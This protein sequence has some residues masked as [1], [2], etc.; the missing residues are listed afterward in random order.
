MTAFNAKDTIED[1]LWSVTNQTFSD[2]EVVIVDD[3]S[4]DNTE[5]VVAPFL[6]DSRIRL[7]K[8]EY[9]IGA[10]ASRNRAANALSA[11]YIAV[12]DADD[13][14]LPSRLEAQ[15]AAFDRDPRLE[16]LGAQVAEFGSWGGP[17]VG[18]AWPTTNA[19]IQA[20]L[21]SLK[22]PL[23]HPTLMIKRDLLLSVGGYATLPRAQDFALMQSLRGRQ[24]AALPSVQ[25]LYRTQRPIPLNYVLRSGRDG[26]RVRRSVTSKPAELT[27]V[28]RTAVDAR[29]AITWAR[30]RV[31]EGGR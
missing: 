22:M 4:T 27:L 7:I 6:S 21:E 30:R 31:R 13:L 16:V 29:S 14:C 9:N 20:K 8:N 10:G 28:R 2:W 26:W 18:A 23:A 5:S 12:L 1:A 19:E 17:S 11:E 15:L 24:F 3:A 25:V